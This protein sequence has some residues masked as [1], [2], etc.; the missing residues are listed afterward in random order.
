MATTQTQTSQHTDI[1]LDLLKTINNANI[2][3]FRQALHDT[4]W[5]IKNLDIHAT[6][7]EAHAWMQA[8]IHEA[9]E[10][11]LNDA[12]AIK[13]CKSKLTPVLRPVGAGPGPCGIVS[14]PCGTGPGPCDV[15]GLTPLGGSI[16]FSGMSSGD[17][18]FV[19]V[20]M[21]SMWYKVRLRKFI[22][23]AKTVFDNM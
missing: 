14:R 13:L 23:R 12:Q 7:Y 21:D 5:N 9:E 8:F 2:Q 19:A 15:D 18:S 10:H 17:M 22:N 16:S 4:A 1:L 3:T 11:Q 20:S 6:A